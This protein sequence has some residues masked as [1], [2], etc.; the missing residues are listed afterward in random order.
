M[1]TMHDKSI[2]VASYAAGASLAAIA[3]VYVFAPTYFID[4]ESGSARKKG[5]VG[6]RNPANDCFINSVLQALAG[7][8]ELRVYLIREKHRRDIEDPSVYSYL[9]QPPNKT[10]PEWKVDVQQKGIVT[11]GLKEMLDKLNERPINKKTISA[12]EF[13]RVLEQAFRQRISRQQQDAQEFLQI[14]AETLKEEY[15]AGERAREHAKKTW[16]NATTAKGNHELDEKAV[17]EKLAGLAIQNGS[18]PESARTSLPVVPRIQTEDEDE[19]MMD[20]EDDGFPMEG[21]YESQSECQTCGFKTKPREET[22]CTM[23]LN[24]PQV[25][26]TTLSACFDDVFK[27]EYVD[28]FKC[29]KCRLL[30]AKDVL[31]QELATSTSETFKTGLRADLEQLQQAIDK[32]PEHPPEGVRLPDS[33]YAPKRKIA[34]STRMTSFPRILAI[35]LSRSIYDSSQMS[36][37]N[38]A[39]V[40]F[41]ERLPLGGLVNQRKYKL[42]GVVTH[43]GS[44]HSG[45]YESFRRQNTYPPYS[46][47]NTFRQS[48]VYS[49]SA[50]PSAT[51]QLDAV[52]RA[53]SPMA[54]TPDLLSPSSGT[55]SSTPSLDSNAPASAQA[56]EPAPRS[57]PRSSAPWLTASPTPGSRGKDGSETASIRSVAASAKSTLSKLSNSKPANGST[58]GSPARSAA[59]A[60]SPKPAAKAAQPPRYRKRKVNDRWWRISDE[61]IR[62]CRTGEVLGMQREVY[63]LFYELEKEEP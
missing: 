20:E 25:Q 62:E 26:S 42:L 52:S 12:I 10:L 31:E 17:D 56:S 3:L 40:S 28:D 5:I 58:P 57:S 55:N 29:D 50:S 45:H 16:E 63:L 6:L 19:K 51:P 48:G 7:L 8:G 24:V 35:H 43:K 15:R 2:T 39:K 32:D 46:N 18:A 47:S 21:K 27:T 33:K 36:Q 59:A 22:F 53:D 60:V 34:R 61:K 13:V 38:S 14:V 4:G 1:N 49:K 11:R 37:K 41:P 44:H 23:T 30:H 54:S 9:V